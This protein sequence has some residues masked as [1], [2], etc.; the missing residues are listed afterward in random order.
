[1]EVGQ[2]QMNA[3]NAL[4]EDQAD[5]LNRF[6]SIDISQVPLLKSARDSIWES[7]KNSKQIENEFHLLNT[8]PALVAELHKSIDTGNNVQSAVFS[9]CVYAQSQPFYGNWIHDD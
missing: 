3:T 9:E 5:L 7:F 1:M 6:Y 4:S 8:C 2:F